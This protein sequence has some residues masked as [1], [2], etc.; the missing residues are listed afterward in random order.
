[1]SSCYYSK[2]YNY[3]SEWECSILTQQR[4]IEFC[5]VRTNL[6]SLSLAKIELLSKKLLHCMT[7]NSNT[8]LGNRCSL[9][10][11]ILL[12]QL[13]GPTFVLTAKSIGTRPAISYVIIYM[14]VVAGD[15]TPKCATSATTPCQLWPKIAFPHNIGVRVWGSKATLVGPIHIIRPSSQACT[16]TYHNDRVNYIS[17][18]YTK[19]DI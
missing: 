9:P 4:H 19:Y 16:P 13:Y 5:N 7:L 14:E 17:N 3:C 1:M 6:W 8:Q 10:W 15:M 2:C 18:K 11:Y 12:I